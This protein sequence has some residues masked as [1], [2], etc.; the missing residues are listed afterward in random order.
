MTL[1]ITK[2]PLGLTCHRS[3]FGVAAAAA[4]VLFSASSPHDLCTGARSPNDRHR[5]A[6]DR[7]AS[8]ALTQTCSDSA[9]S[10]LPLYTPVPRTPAVLSDTTAAVGEGPC[11]HPMADRHARRI[12]QAKTLSMVAP[13]LLRGHAGL[14]KEPLWPQTWSSP[15]FLLFFVIA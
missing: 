2:R 4:L 15:S 6:A 1:N 7:R 11:A 13:I 12:W 5:A 14:P 9:H 3:R 10:T 8:N